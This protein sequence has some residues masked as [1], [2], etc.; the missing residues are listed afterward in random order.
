MR[1]TSPNQAGTVLMEYVIILPLYFLVLMGVAQFAHLW[2]AKHVTHYAAYSGARSA[3]VHADLPLSASGP[4]HDSLPTAGSFG[5]RGLDERYK[6]DPRGFRTVIM[7]DS[8]RTEV[9]H[10]A[11][12]V[13]TRICAWVSAAG[14]TEA[15]YATPWGDIRGS[16]S[17]DRKVRASVDYTDW[18]MEVTVEHDFPMI[19]PIVGPAIGWLVDPFN[20]DATWE[21]REDVDSTN[22]AH[23]DEDSVGYPHLR[24]TETVRIPKPNQT[25][26]AAGT[27]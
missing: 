25:I 1:A 20:P 7:P 18:V 19:F 22:N 23:M 16:A 12:Q 8:P 13:A 6:V 17:M 11:N 2:V 5:H 24:L 4:N 3:L 9:E 10:A 15:G 26:I 27:P 14:A 21:A